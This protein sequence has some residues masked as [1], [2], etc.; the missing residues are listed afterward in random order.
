VRIAGLAPFALLV[1]LVATRTAHAA[2]NDFRLNGRDKAGQ[3]ILFHC[4]NRMQNPDN[5]TAGFAADNGLFNAFVT[6]LGYVFA[7]RL[8]SPA[9]TLGH[10]GFHI[11]ALWSGTTVSNDQPYWG[12]TERAQNGQDPRGFLQTLQLE[13]RKGLPFSFELG[14]NF[15]WL[16]ESQLFAPGI[17]VRWALQEGYKYIP[18]LG[19]RGS[20]NHMVGN[21]DLLLTTVGLDAVISKSFGL[22]GMVNVAPYL[23]WSLIMIAASSRVI[24]PTPTVE[25]NPNNDIVFNEIN[26]T[27]KIHHKLTLGVRTIYYVLNVSVQGELQMAEG[28]FIGPVA[29][30]TTKLGLD[31]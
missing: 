23:S 21:R 30:I 17:E 9:E 5:C 19:I 20:V 1:L 24:N 25:G 12:V 28:S 3:G 18:D 13:V 7:P 4:N 10:S 16:V 6:Q 29:T 14:A 8:A 11:G 15:M 26:A 22:F 31:F 2:D 27:D